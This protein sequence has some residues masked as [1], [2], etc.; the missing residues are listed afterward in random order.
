MPSTH[1]PHQEVNHVTEVFTFDPYGVD[2]WQPTLHKDCWNYPRLDPG[3]YAD[4]LHAS[5]AASPNEIERIRQYQ[6][7]SALYSAGLPMELL[8]EPY[9]R[10]LFPSDCLNALGKRLKPAPVF[11]GRVDKYTNR[12]V[13]PTTYFSPN[14]T[15]RDAW[16]YICPR[17]PSPN[18]S[19]YEKGDVLKTPTKDR[20]RA[21][22]TSFSSVE[23]RPTLASVR[24]RLEYES[25][26][27][28]ETV[29]M[30]AR[31][32]RPTSAEYEEIR[33]DLLL[34][35][36]T[37]AKIDVTPSSP[38]DGRCFEGQAQE[39]PPRYSPISV[40]EE[41]DE[42]SLADLFCEENFVEAVPVSDEEEERE[43]ALLAS[44]EM[45]WYDLPAER[46]RSL[47]ALVREEKLR[48]GRQLRASHKSFANQRRVMA[49]TS[50]RY[51]TLADAMKKQRRLD[52]LSNRLAYHREK[53]G[54]AC[55]R[56]DGLQCCID[57]REERTDY[58][59]TDEAAAGAAFCMPTSTTADD[60]EK[61]LC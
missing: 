27:A 53:Y 39:M 48:L 4:R 5:Y 42:P 36:M 40:E 10:P 41:E 13:E 30:P 61:D 16:R 26:K 49:R 18:P 44:E 12:P 20:K 56:V 11:V 57:A 25:Q 19:A 37:E 3:T 33:K 22:S 58:S 32:T 45:Y 21:R 35:A 9:P 51:W 50:S 17:T 31:V 60:Y 55:A 1:T 14:G 8:C 52:E 7:R 6:A 15:K 43:V 2:N 59:P 38:F 47:S 28:S 34:A 46:L 29:V 23:Q 54:E 24:R